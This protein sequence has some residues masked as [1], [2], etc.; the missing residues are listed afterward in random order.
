M[1]GVQHLTL[2]IIIIIICYLIQL[3]SCVASSVGRSALVVVGIV[4]GVGCQVLV[5]VQSGSLPA[6]SRSLGDRRR[7]PFVFLIAQRVILASECLLLRL[8]L[9]LDRSFGFSFSEITGECV[10][11]AQYMSFRTEV[12]GVVPKWPM[13]LIK[14]RCRLTLL[15][16]FASLGLAAWL[17]FAR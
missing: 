12:N 6:C 4:V 10:Q 5:L 13:P 11:L 9:R 14:R 15:R 8:H 2:F 17:G 3:R 16:R 1:S 7:P